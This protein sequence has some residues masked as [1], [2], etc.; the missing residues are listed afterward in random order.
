METKTPTT[1]ARNTKENTMTTTEKKAITNILNADHCMT[2]AD[3]AYDKAQAALFAITAMLDRSLE[4][5]KSNHEAG[6]ASWA[7]TGDLQ[8]WAENLT[9]IADP[10]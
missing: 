6:R 9:D 5:A 7:V 2:A 4:S 10:K 1:N 3:A 8:S